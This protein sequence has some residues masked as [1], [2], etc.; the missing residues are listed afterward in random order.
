MV[1]KKRKRSNIQDKVTFLYAI[2]FKKINYQL[3]KSICPSVNQEA[4]LRGGDE[5][6]GSVAKSAS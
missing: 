2:I 1:E 5:P 6:L 3:D 4:L